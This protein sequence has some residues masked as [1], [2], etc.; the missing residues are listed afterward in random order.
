M[1]KLSASL[2]RFNRELKEFTDKRVPRE[3]IKIQRKISLEAL[4]RIVL[5]TPVDTGLARGNWQLTINSPTDA[6]LTRIDPSG[7]GAINAGINSLANLPPFATIYIQ[8]NLD[9]ILNLEQGSST[10]APQG[11]VAITLA[12]L[13]ST[14]R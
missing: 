3:I 7:G 4:K 10:Q 2:S 1:A 11:M 6:K 9:Y 12:E 5:R 13:Q 8:N 14:F